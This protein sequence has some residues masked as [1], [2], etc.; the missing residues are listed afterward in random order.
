[1]GC[2]GTA[3]IFEYRTALQLQR[4]NHRQIA[5]REAA[6]CDAVVSEAIIAFLDSTSYEDAINNAISLAGDR[7]TLACITGGIAQAFYGDVPDYIR[8]KV[9][10][11]LTPDLLGIAEA[12]QRKYMH[13]SRADERV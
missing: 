6:A 8:S 13:V 11:C 1:M 4:L 5:L 10:E 2:H 7:N 9:R 3:Q 12:F